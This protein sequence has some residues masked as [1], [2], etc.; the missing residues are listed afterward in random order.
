[1]DFIDTVVKYFSNNI[2][3]STL[4]AIT[5]FIIGSIFSSFFEPFGKRMYSFLIPPK[6]SIKIDFEKLGMSYPSKKTINSGGL[7]GMP[8]EMPCIIDNYKYYIKVTNTSEIDL[9]NINLNLKHEEK[10]N[11]YIKEKLYIDH[12]KVG[13]TTNLC[14]CH[15]IDLVNDTEIQISIHA[16]EFKKNIIQN[17]I[18]S[19]ELKRNWH[20]GRK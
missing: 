19:T 2:L 3:L 8:I 13:E 14:I 20:L 16:K 1:M 9:N 4:V 11:G 12:L 17:K 7:L 5:F 6:V 10:D 15:E 18:L